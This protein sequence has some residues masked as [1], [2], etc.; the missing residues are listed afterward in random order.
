MDIEWEPARS[1]AQA[2]RVWRE[3]LRPIA[4]ELEANARRLGDE[5]TAALQG[6]FPQWF[7][8]AESI[9][10]SSKS[11]AASVQLFARLVDQGA[12]PRH[13]PLP[14]VTLDAARAGVERRVA[15]AGVLRSYR[16]GHEMIWQFL[17]DR[18][19]AACTDAA[20]QAAAINLASGWLFAYI[21]AAV[22]KGEV[23]Y[24]AEREAWMR[25]A[26]A[27]RAEGIDAILAGR[28]RD[29]QRA[30]SRLRYELGR[31]HL[32]VITWNTGS[33]QDAASRG[34]I[35]DLMAEIAQRVR[36]EATLT[37]LIGPQTQAAWLSRAAPFTDAELESCC[38]S[39][40]HG[41]RVAL[42]EPAHGL[43]GLRR[44]HIEAG[45]ARRVATLT[46]PHTAPLTRYQHVAVTAMATMDGE[47]ARTF[48]TRVLGPLANDDETTFRLA[49]TLAAYLD[50]NRSPSRAA[51]RLTIHP[52]TVAY[53]VNQARQLLDRSI[54]QDTLDLRVALALLPALRSL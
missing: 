17:F 31:Q 7:P 2:Q 22:A 54:E 52:N 9:M 47:Q 26:A 36:A 13:S 15:L 51:E 49:M 19:T 24:E 37:H 42:G 8:D 30:A 53:R 39:V 33:G 50:E 28:E 18:I 11:T 6:E 4:G 34:V 23:R 35:E 45:H 20:E 27:S 44:T 40:P 43:D 41:M 1:S 12:D 16:L 25:S 5:A 14:P 21:D 46:E 10:L 48:I 32:G 29:P 38:P 3:V